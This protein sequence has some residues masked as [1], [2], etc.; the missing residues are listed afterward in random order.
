MGIQP[1]KTPRDPHSADGALLRAAWKGILAAE[2]GPGAVIWGE[3]E[4]EE[5]EEEGAEA[6][7]EEEGGEGEGEGEGGRR[8]WAWFEWE[9]LSAHEG[10]ART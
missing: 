3:E 9:S 2:G 10:F 7:K 4:E 8:L 1:S 6:E 5:E